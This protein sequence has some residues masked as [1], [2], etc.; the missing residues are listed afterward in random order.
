MRTRAGKSR[1]HGHRI[2]GSVRTRE[3]RRSRSH[4]R[5]WRSLSFVTAAV[6]A[7]S[8]LTVTGALSAPTP[9]SAESQP[10]NTRVMSPQVWHVYVKA[11]EQLRVDFRNHSNVA[12]STADNQRVRVISPDGAVA[13]DCTDLAAMGSVCEYLSPAQAADGVWAVE[14]YR[15]DGSTK[16]ARNRLTWTI[17]PIAA[18]GTPVPGRVWSEGYQME[19]MATLPELSFWVQTEYGYSYRMDLRGYRGVNSALFANAF[20]NVDGASCGSVYQSLGFPN[21][22]SPRG[23][24]PVNEV[25]GCAGYEPYKLF[26]SEPAADLPAR[27][28]L[29]GGDTT[30]LIADQVEPTV[31]R[32]EFARSDA[33]LGAR[34]GTVSIAATEYEGNVS[35]LID[36]DGDGT[37]DGPSD[38]TETVALVDPGNSGV[39][40]AEYAFDGLDARGEVIPDST[41]VAFRVAITR[42]AEVHFTLSDVE[43]LEGGIE[44]TR[45]N[46]PAA[47]RDRLFWNDTPLTDEAWDGQANQKC[48]SVPTPLET[49]AANGVPSAG[50]V[51]GWNAEGCD[52]INGSAAYPGGPWGNNRHLDHWAYV[53]VADDDAVT[54]TIAVPGVEITKAASA[55][56]EPL[57]AGGTVD[58]TVTARAVPYAHEAELSEPQTHWGGR[59]SDD[60]TGVLDDATLTA[61]LDTTIG[62][63]APASPLQPA[64][65]Q[66]GSDT[67]WTWAGDGVPLA[68]EVAVTYAATLNAFEGGA[69][70]GDGHVL[71]VAFTHPGLEAPPFP[72]D[73]V[74]KNSET[75]QTTEQLVAALQAA[76]QADPIRETP[77][78]PG[79]TLT[80][81]LEFVNEGTAVAEIDATDHLAGLL[82]DA[83][84]VRIL[85]VAVTP[86]NRVVM[87]EVVGETIR[88]TGEIEPGDTAVVT[89]EAVVADAGA[90]DGLLENYLVRGDAEPPAAC[91][92]GNLL[93]TV[94]FVPQVAIEKSFDRQS[95]RDLDGSGTVSIGDQLSFGFTVTN[96]GRTTLSP[97]TV[98]DPML[99]E[100]GVTVVC[101]ASRLAPGAQTS[102]AQNRAYV[103]SAD[104][105]EAGK[106]VN[107]ATATGGHAGPAGTV[108][109]ESNTV[110][111][112]IVPVESGLTLVK[113]LDKSVHQTGVE[114]VNGNGLPD[115]GDLVWFA[116]TLENTGDTIVRDPRIVD[117]LLDEAGIAIEC[118][119]DLI[120]PGATL[121]CAA[122]A[123]YAITAADVENERVVNT[124]SA[125]GQASTGAVIAPD[126]TI[127]VPVVEPAPG[128]A[129]KKSLNSAKGE[130][131]I[132][133][134]DLSGTNSP[135]DLVWY[136][137]DVTN[138]GN[139]AVADLR[140]VDGL[141]ADAGITV[142]C[143]S[144]DL[145]P[146]AE[147]RCVADAGLAMTPDDAA[148]GKLTNTA[149][150]AATAP[151]GDTVA[152]KE[153]VHELPVVPARV[154]LAI[155][156]ALNDAEGAGGITDSNG[157]GLID[158]GDLVWYAFTV[159][160]TGEVPLSAVSISDAKLPGDGQITCAATSLAPGAETSCVAT[161][162]VAITA[163]EAT[164]GVATNTATASAATAAG[165]SVESLPSTV[166]VPT[167]V[168]EPSLFAQKHLA[169]WS[170]LDGSGTLSRG[171]TLDYEFTVWNDGNTPL[172]ALSVEDH[173]LADAGI[174]VTCAAVEL[175]PGAHMTCA[176]DAGYPVSASEAAAGEV[177]NTAVAVGAAGEAGEIRSPETALVTPVAPVHP[178][179]ALIKRLNTDAPGGGTEDVN[180][181][182]LVN[183]GDAIWYA[184][185][186][187]NQGDLPLTAVALEDALLTGAGVE[188][189]CE[190]ADPLLP[191]AVARCTADAGYEVTLDDEAAG[192][193]HNT[194][195]VT[196]E[197]LLGDAV[198]SPT[199]AH[200]TWLTVARP[201]IAIEKRL[202]RTED[203]DSSGMV[204]A[205]DLLWYGFTVTNIGNVPL[206]AVA[207]DDPLLAEAGVDV[208]CAAGELAPGATVECAA[209]AGYE[210]PGDAVADRRVVNVSAAAAAS[211]AGGTEN[212]T[213]FEL[214]TTVYPADDG[215]GPGG[216]GAPGGPGSP[217]GPGTPGGPSVIGETGGVGPLGAAAIAALLL[218]LGAL[219]A[220]KRL[221][222]QQRG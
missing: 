12:G 134:L 92:D 79:E 99:A 44:I 119:A 91:D 73:C 126:A 218:V 34:A 61:G 17:E 42:Y 163:E 28:A 183:A 171:D 181:D 6:L 215:E 153:S 19:D 141:L 101:D 200:T 55:S 170:D 80:Y 179:L 83:G 63:T 140:V 123:G 131:G 27:V 203:L 184:F 219:L 49:D 168:A 54:R 207:V 154:S 26:F 47:G 7:A 82:D 214:V 211:P 205:G 2:D 10:T 70:T 149:T 220:S 36:T 194:A 53:D 147:T 180:G 137:F 135:G 118:G 84:D 94:H 15:A 86:S 158:A 77:V 78:T 165:V 195:R 50:G 104:D 198:A 65:W 189:S 193:V 127:T 38:R 74:A 208:T 11:G 100:A 69:P 106:I 32:L 59:V 107:V 13:K 132:E 93:C 122:V 143:E 146:G 48:G 81:S 161:E 60:L 167:A 196:G 35:L 95:W 66:A 64:D 117:E 204:T 31:S 5:A 67:L 125:L 16:Q 178:A 23:Y 128:L 85:D 9:A 90:G 124:A 191:H 57:E 221:A 164:S 190:V 144:A 29:P 56:S 199:A 40:S 173:L 37:F 162:G 45:L 188:V 115:E 21:N 176:A 156:K 216:P 172:S 68:D 71:N 121:D 210:V 138:T 212:S 222:R 159:S 114:D 213:P 139:V 130:G 201:G 192:R 148:N 75:C 157:N 142:S 111:V 24:A 113:R 33:Q 177:V 8:G 152:A 51:H 97:V 41:P 182:G 39:A 103:V 58:Y 108:H 89:Y 110:E 169:G 102:C 150:A 187:V 197:T 185:E 136:A 112:P 25:P 217:G 76:K 206:S 202:D 18:T 145:A 22:P 116:F 175:A 43:I 105:V 120:A 14:T 186:V 20:G 96:T 151:G 155:D 109:A 52:N 88:V 160:N 166:D 46:G 3:S 174:G 30:W 133:D 1:N 62:G 87:A 129:I 72:E 209:V 4:A 98:T